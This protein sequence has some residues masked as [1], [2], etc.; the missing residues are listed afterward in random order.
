MLAICRVLLKP[1]A[2]SRGWWCYQCVD[3]NGF[4][5]ATGKCVGSSSVHPI[6][7]QNVWAG[8]KQTICL[9]R[10]LYTTGRCSQE[11][12]QTCNPVEVLNEHLLLLL[13]R[14]FVPIK[15]IRV[16]NK[17]EPWLMIYAGMLLASSR[18]FIFGGPVIAL[19]F[20]VPRRSI[21]FRWLVRLG[22]LKVCW[23]QADF[24]H[25][26]KGPLSSSVA[27]YRPI[28]MTSVLSKVFERQVSVRLGRFIECSGCASNNQICLSE[29]SG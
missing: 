19:R 4:R 2:E 22:S 21:V 5:R 12:R 1:Q 20:A 29:R 7:Q 16:R 25:I 26:L 13:V 24:T 8:R 27:N 28:S 6:Y 23:R 11:S 18:R 17:D 3:R 10:W 14:R 15:V 9:C